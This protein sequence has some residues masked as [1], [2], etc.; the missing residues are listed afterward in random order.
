MR[1]FTRR[2]N[3]NTIHF[4]N[5]YFRSNIHEVVIP[6]TNYEGD[7]IF[8]KVL[9]ETLKH[10]RIV[11]TTLILAGR[12]TGKYH[13]DVLFI[14]EAA[15]ASETEACCA[16]ALMEKGNKII[17]AGDPKQLGPSL[18]SEKAVEYGFGLY[19]FLNFNYVYLFCLSP[20]KCITDEKQYE[21]R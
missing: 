10:Y 15:Q 1:S 6:Y 4:L 7:D 14:D 3:K 13:P 16:I 12:F 19:F 11:V 8:R 2:N 5:I 20:V 21:K 17:L 9:P 18:S